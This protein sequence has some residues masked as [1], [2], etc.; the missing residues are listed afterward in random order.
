MSPAVV[1]VVL[2]VAASLIYGSVFS[3]NHLK[4]IFGLIDLRNYHAWRVA[5]KPD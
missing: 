5:S 2:L 4:P 1:N 3:L